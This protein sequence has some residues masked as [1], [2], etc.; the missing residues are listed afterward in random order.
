MQIRYVNLVMESLNALRES[1]TFESPRVVLDE[2]FE[3]AK[4][5]CMIDVAL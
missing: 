5:M 2:E 1:R 3:D 4:G